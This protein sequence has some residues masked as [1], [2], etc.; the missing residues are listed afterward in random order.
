M[1]AFCQGMHCLC[2]FVSYVNLGHAQ[3]LDMLRLFD[4]LRW[5][6]LVRCGSDIV[7]HWWAGNCMFLL[8]GFLHMPSLL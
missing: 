3:A 1:G 2:D 6:D 7:S 5:S 4:V 8:E